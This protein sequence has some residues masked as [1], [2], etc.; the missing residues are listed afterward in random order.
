MSEGGSSKHRWI[1]HLMLFS[2]AKNVHDQAKVLRP[3]Q[4]TCNLK[5]V[6]VQKAVL[7]GADFSLWAAWGTTEQRPTDIC[8]APWVR[9]EKERAAQIWGAVVII[10]IVLVKLVVSDDKHDNNHEHYNDNNHSNTTTTTNNNHDNVL[11]LLLL[12]IMIMI[13]MIMIIMIIMIGMLWLYNRYICI[14][15]YIYIHDTNNDN[16]NNDRI[17]SAEPPRSEPKRSGPCDVG[18][19]ASQDLSIILFLQYLFYNIVYESLCDNVY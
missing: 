11:L 2:V 3:N 9:A 18:S 12:I 19:F 13:I 15:I 10:A 7:S 14:Y 17:T 4:H 6:R 8:W 5:R 16:D 1:K